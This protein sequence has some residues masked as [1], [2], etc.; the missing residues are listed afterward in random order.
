[1]HKNWILT[2]IL[3]NFKVIFVKSVLI[4]CLL[5]LDQYGAL[6]MCIFWTTMYFCKVVMN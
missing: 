2:F 4:S 3:E 5:M 1:M 6:K